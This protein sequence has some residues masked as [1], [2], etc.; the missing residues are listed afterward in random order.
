MWNLNGLRLKHKLVAMQLVTASLVLLFFGAI[1][2]LGGLR[3]ARES[4]VAK[5]A[6]TAELLGSNSLSALDFSDREAAGKVLASL[7]AEPDVVSACLCDRDN[8]VFAKY[9]RQG[10]PDLA[11]AARPEDGY[12]FSE[13]NLTLVRRVKSNGETLGT[14]RLRSDMG[15]YHRSAARS[16]LVA[17]AGLGLGLLA[18]FLLA[19][20]TQKSI[21]EPILRLVEAAKP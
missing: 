19:I 14:I 9:S 5:L 2:L 18:A 7:Q 10:R 12:E 21:S 11:P 16:V 4:E 13:G 15:A 20:Q 1:N 8:K 3:A 17:L 6:A